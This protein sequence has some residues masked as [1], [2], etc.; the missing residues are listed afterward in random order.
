MPL[1]F[2]YWQVAEEF[3]YTNSISLIFVARQP[4]PS[5]SLAASLG[6]VLDSLL[7][8]PL[9]DAVGLFLHEHIS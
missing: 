7:A 4:G 5:F 2:H 6:G 3:S 1:N 9:I 8:S